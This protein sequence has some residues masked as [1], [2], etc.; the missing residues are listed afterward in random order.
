MGIIANFLIHGL[1]PMAMQIE[2]LKHQQFFWVKPKLVILESLKYVAI[3]F[4]L[5]VK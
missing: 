4:C 3:L 1:K 5:V 2:S